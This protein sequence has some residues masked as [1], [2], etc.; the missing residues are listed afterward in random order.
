MPPKSN[1]EECFLG[2]VTVGERGQIVIP[3][4]ARKRLGIHTGERLI[5]LCHPNEHGIAFLKIDTMRDMLNK[6]A[7][8]LSAFESETREP[9]EDAE[10]D[11]GDES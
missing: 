1:P 9:S 8:R 7:E 2:T 3:A 4:E 5:A 11:A 10:S 6:M